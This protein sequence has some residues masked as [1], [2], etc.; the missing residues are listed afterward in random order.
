V[1]LGLERGVGRLWAV[2]R[3][4]GRGRLWLYSPGRGGGA[5]AGYET[6][7]GLL[8]SRS[9][10]LSLLALSR[11]EANASFLARG[12]IPSPRHPPRAGVG[13]AEAR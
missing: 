8:C 3:T 10:P 9:L 1:V 13:A 12:L 5:A 7:Y 2:G 4:R 6:G 11:S